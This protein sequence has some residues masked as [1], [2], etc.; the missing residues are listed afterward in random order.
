[1]DETLG[2][3]PAP[4]RDKLRQEGVVVHGHVGARAGV[5]ARAAIFR[6][7]AAELVGN[8]IVAGLEAQ[9]IDVLLYLRA[10]GLVGGAAQLVVLCRDAV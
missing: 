10:C 6:D 4:L 9:R 1:M 5:E 3:Q 7:E 8:G 2:V